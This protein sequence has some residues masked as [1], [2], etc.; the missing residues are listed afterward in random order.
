MGSF[1]K[2]QKFSC[3]LPQSTTTTTTTKRKEKKTKVSGVCQVSLCSLF[4][5]LYLFH[6]APTALGFIHTSSP[7]VFSKRK[8]KE[9]KRWRREGEGGRVISSVYG[10]VYWRHPVTPACSS[11]ISPHV[12][13]EI[14][15]E[16]RADQEMGI[17][18]VGEEVV[19]SAGLL[20]S[21]VR[22]QEDPPPSPLLFRTLMGGDRAQHKEKMK[23]KTWAVTTAIV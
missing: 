23:M 18:V 19:G 10:V 17:F 8:R 21:A 14:Q 5:S 9:K 2:S 22:G 6:C 3:S 4:S 13:M 12:W 7:L 11:L 20:C 1:D 15:R 16:G